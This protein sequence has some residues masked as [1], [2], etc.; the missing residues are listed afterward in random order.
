MATKK[1]TGTV[2]SSSTSKFA[3]D[4]S[5]EEME[6]KTYYGQI[7]I[8]TGGKLSFNDSPTTKGMK[9]VIFTSFGNTDPVTAGFHMN[10]ED[11][12]D[13]I[14][15]VLA[16]SVKKK[17]LGLNPNTVCFT[18]QSYGGGFIDSLL[19]FSGAP[20]G[21]TLKVSLEGPA[22]VG[23]SLE[24]KKDTAHK[25]WVE[26]AEAAT[27]LRLM[28]TPTAPVERRMTATE[29]L[30]ARLA[31]IAANQGISVEQDQKLTQKV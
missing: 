9:N 22:K 27:K 6:L 21:V 28:D 5:L 25:A 1:V 23:T 13:F 31:A 24:E 12:A 8:P 18:F 15:A 11:T 20:V 14:E 10:E 29:K 7:I 19:W 3:I 4:E 26:N 16:V 30:N 2:A 17:Q